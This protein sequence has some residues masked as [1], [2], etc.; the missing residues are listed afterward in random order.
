MDSIN[1]QQQAIAIIKQLSKEKLEAAFNYLSYL[2]AKE[3]LNTSH[4]LKTDVEIRKSP[5]RGIKVEEHKCK[6][7]EDPLL[8]L[9]GTLKCDEENISDR[10]DEIIGDVLLADRERFSQPNRFSVKVICKHNF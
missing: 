10:H 9:L 8:A 1:L 4:E 7:N 5:R 2:Q 6:N 3:I